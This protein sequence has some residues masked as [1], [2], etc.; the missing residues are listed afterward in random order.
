MARRKTTYCL[1]MI[2]TRSADGL[3][4]AQRE[5][6]MRQQAID[7]YDSY[8]HGGMDRRSFLDR[9]AA[10]VGGTAAAAALLPILENNYAKADLVAQDDPRLESADLDVPGIAGL[11]GLL[12]RPKGAAK[13]A[14]VLVIH[15]NRGL[16]P[17][18]RDVTRRMALEGFNAL[19]LDYLSPAGGTPE[20][21]DKA[22]DM[23]GKME[24]GA[25]L[26]SSRA[27]VDFLAKHPLSTGAVGAIGFCWGGGAV[28]EL[29]AA[30]TVLKAGV[31]Y[32]G[33]QLDAARVSEITA[34]LMLHY[35]SLDERINAGI[36]D[37][38]AALKAANKPYELHMYQGAN[39]AFNNDT[40]A[41]RYNKAA[42]DLAWSRTVAFLK[43]KLV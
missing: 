42:A 31:A 14:C 12:V 22:R 26:S 10:L 7:L 19:G 4:L 16:N 6:M 11:K 24:P 35:A 33:R 13:L 27:A 40:N 38:E 32:Y 18:I 28:N 29:A 21:P 9:L 17:H 23:I 34:P 30:G 5:Q 37:F 20:D 15:E 3:L 41:A 8:T 36:A 39:H 43:A 1:V 2:L 25:A